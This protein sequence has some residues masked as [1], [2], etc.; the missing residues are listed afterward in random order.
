MIR[1][2]L[3]IGLIVI[4]FA[5][6]TKIVDQALLKEW[7]AMVMA[8][9]I[10]SYA[11]FTKGIRCVDNKWIIFSI[12]AMVVSTMFVPDSQLYLGAIKP[13]GAFVFTD[14]NVD[15]IWNFKP[16][17]LSILYLLMASAIAQEEW[18][19]KEIVKIISWVG[20]L[21]A[22]VVI[23][24]KFGFQ[25]FWRV[26]EAWEVGLGAKNMGLTG[27]M[28]QYTLVASFMAICFVATLFL[29]QFYFSIVIAIAILLTGCHFAILSIIIS[30]A[31]RFGAKYSGSFIL[32]LL[33]IIAT[34]LIIDHFHHFN[35]DG[36]YVVWQQIL[37]DMTHPIHDVK[38]GPTYG[39]TGFGAG[40]FGLIFSILHRSPWG[41]AHNE[42][43]EF[44]FNNGI[45]GLGI[46][47]TAVG[48][49]FKQCLNLYSNE[50]M[51]FILLSFLA[52]CVLSCGTFVWHLGWGQFYTVAIIGLAYSAIRKQGEQKC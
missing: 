51:K 36:R 21:M 41:K 10:A 11:L 7:L 12:G 31:L 27:F 33:A 39:F 48:I 43:L 40:A 14:L 46:F 22:F 1:Q 6:L 17:F 38:E 13:N 16:M 37:H 4:P 50:N 42:F 5:H 15:N 47:L 26:R 8:L 35:D 44:L 19:I 25:Q 45:F 29:E 18:N 9:S 52:T 24:Q 32:I 34:A 23:V 28:A 2:L 30:T 49:F 3:I 20:F